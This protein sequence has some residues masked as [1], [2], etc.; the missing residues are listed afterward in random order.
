MGPFKQ[1]TLCHDHTG[2]MLTRPGLTARPKGHLGRP[3]PHTRAGFTH[4][5]HAHTQAHACHTHALRCT[6]AVSPGSVV[7]CS[8]EH[9]AEGSP[10]NMSAD[11]PGH[12]LGP[13]QPCPRLFPLHLAPPGD[14]PL[15]VIF[16][17]PLRGSV[18]VAD[19]RSPSKCTRLPLGEATEGQ[20]RRREGGGAKQVQ[21]TPQPSFSQ[22]CSA[23]ACV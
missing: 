23:D 16:L 22:R 12:A 15:M 21:E 6:H 2:H 5:P 18:K 9:C 3:P 13:P 10:A 20:S 7:G 8:G 14:D 17:V 4:T 1:G 19:G 11:V